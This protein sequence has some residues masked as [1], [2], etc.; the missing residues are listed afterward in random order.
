MLFICLKTDTKKTCLIEIGLHAQTLLTI[1]VPLVNIIEGTY[2]IIW[3]ER[4]FT[5]EDN[6]F[7]E[8]PKSEENG[9]RHYLDSLIILH[10]VHVSYPTIS[11]CRAKK[12][13]FKT[14]LPGKENAA[15]LSVICSD[16][17]SRAPIIT[18]ATAGLSAIYR[19]ATLLMLTLCFSAI[20]PRARRSSWNQPIL[21][22]I[23]WTLKYWCPGC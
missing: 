17:L 22:V 14:C 21:W 12:W 15:W 8:P 3:R 16:M 20:W 4:I 5:L 11:G 6:I 7:I 9:Y 23:N 13:P 10:W 1:L 18:A 2:Q 19:T